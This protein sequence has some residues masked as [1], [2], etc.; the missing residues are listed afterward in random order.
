MFKTVLMAAYALTISATVAQ[1][2]T[3]FDPPEKVA[4]EHHDKCV[5]WYGYRPGT[6]AYGSCRQHLE[7]LASCKRRMFWNTLGGISTFCACGQ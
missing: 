6:P 1:A 2:A 7:C 5:Q 3:I 4:Q